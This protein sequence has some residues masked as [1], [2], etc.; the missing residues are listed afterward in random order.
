M[1]ANDRALRP[2]DCNGPRGHFSSTSFLLYLF[3]S[4]VEPCKRNQISVGD[5]KTLFRYF[6]FVYTS[7]L[8]FVYNIYVFVDK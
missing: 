7:S 4:V 1:T 2:G 5:R 6:I 8:V 3:Q